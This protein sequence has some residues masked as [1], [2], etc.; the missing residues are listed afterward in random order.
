MHAWLSLMLWLNLICCPCLCSIYTKA[1]DCSISGNKEPVQS[2]FLDWSFTS[3]ISGP[4]P[5][6][7][8]GRCMNLYFF[9]TYKCSDLAQD[10]H[11]LLFSFY[12][13]SL[14]RLSLPFTDVFVLFFLYFFII[15]QYLPS[16]ITI[17][18]N[19]LLLCLNERGRRI[20]SLYQ[21]PPSKCR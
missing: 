20:L 17:E 14:F 16:K 18:G 2:T 19:S 21:V 9:H 10:N 4:A 5:H 12:G 6:N 13:N 15:F 1:N 8:E 3:M 11:W 7:A